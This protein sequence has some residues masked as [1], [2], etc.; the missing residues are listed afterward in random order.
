MDKR[1][2]FSNLLIATSVVVTIISFLAPAILAYGM[3]WFFLLQ[4]DYVSFGIQF[5]L[6]QFLHGG[7]LHLL[8]NS[9]F[10]YMF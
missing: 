3:N 4:R 6:Y 5:L 9:I 7:I 8:M 2:S 1:M 10:I